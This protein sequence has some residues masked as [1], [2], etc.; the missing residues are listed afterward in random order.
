MVTT[1]QDDEPRVTV[2][3]SPRDHYHDAA[4]SL[5]ILIRHTSEP[6]DLVYVIGKPS[7]DVRAHVR[8]EAARVGFT[9]IERDEHPVPNHARNLALERVGTEYVAFIDNDTIVSPG[10]L[11]AL[12]ACADETGAALVG[13]LQLIGPLEDQLIHLAGGFIDI[14]TRPDPTR[15]GSPTG[16][17][18]AR[19]KRCPSP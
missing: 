9:L 3:C 13:P 2:V 11:Q 18:T 14:D 5:E 8:A 12:V 1:G 19:S 15:S 4:E 17:S 6:F 7:R 10:W 16:S